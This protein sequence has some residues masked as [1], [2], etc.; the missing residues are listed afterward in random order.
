VIATGNR[1]DCCREIDNLSG[2]A[3]LIHQ[4]ILLKELF[5]E[6]I[7]HFVENIVQISRNKVLI[8][9]GYISE[10]LSSPKFRQNCVSCL[11]NATKLKL[12]YLIHTFGRGN[13]Y[14]STGG[15]GNNCG[16]LGVGGGQTRQQVRICS[17]SLKKESSIGSKGCCLGYSYDLINRAYIDIYSENLSNSLG[18]TVR[19]LT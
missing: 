5:S 7:Q 19:T 18:C 2:N 17:R 10:N 11:G 1:N 15:L 8:F 9:S 16:L 12:G 14:G 4:R 13:S 6:R 3:K